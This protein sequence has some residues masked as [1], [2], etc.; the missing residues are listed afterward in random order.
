MS[1]TE[2][3]QTMKKTKRDTFFRQIG[4]KIAYERTIHN[5]TQEKLAAATHINQSTLSRVENGKYNENL[6]MTMLLD[7]ADALGITPDIFFQFNEDERALW[8]IP[9][10]AE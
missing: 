3:G 2:T 7:I 8:V 4:A 1:E 10:V 5:I 6:S 9:D